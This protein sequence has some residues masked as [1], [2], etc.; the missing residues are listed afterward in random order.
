MFEIHPLEHL[1]GHMFDIGIGKLERLNLCLDSA[2]TIFMILVHFPNS[3]FCKMG[4][5]FSIIN[6]GEAVCIAGHKEHKVNGLIS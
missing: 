1:Q 5:Q 3:E 6:C 2:L 4:E